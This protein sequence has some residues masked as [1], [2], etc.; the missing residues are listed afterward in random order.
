MPQ[1]EHFKPEINLIKFFGGKFSH[2]F[3]KLYYF[4]NEIFFGQYSEN[5]YLTKKSKLIN[6]K[7]FYDI[8]PKPD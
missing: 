1:L 3:C 5:I 6:Y 4:T 8:D 2:S 7:K